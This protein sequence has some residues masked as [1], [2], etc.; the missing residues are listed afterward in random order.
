MT[1]PKNLHQLNVPVGE[2]DHCWGCHTPQLILVKYGDYQCPYSRESHYIF[3]EL[4]SVLGEKLQVVFRH[5]PQLRIHPRAGHAAEA[6][7]AAGSQGKF[8]EMH[9]YL[10]EHQ[11]QLADSDLV[12]YAIALNLDVDR[13]L[14]EMTADSHVERI[15]AD[16]ESG[17]ASHVTQTPTVF[18][19]GIKYVG[20]LGC[21]ELF[22]TIES[23]IEKIDH[24]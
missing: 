14:Q 15:N 22:S 23:T 5:F 1:S 9:N 11:S 18:I 19:N 17:R 12:E 16:L 10:F 21:N 8:W 4:Q 20:K 6:A 2:R 24:E 13:F 3:R 7:E